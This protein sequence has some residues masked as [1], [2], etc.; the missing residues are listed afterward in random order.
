[1]PQQ[2]P[3]YLDRQIACVR[4]EKDGLGLVKAAEIRRDFGALLLLVGD[5]LQ[6][7]DKLRPMCR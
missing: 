4:L 2:P 5:E 3:S 6:P 1:M 7:L